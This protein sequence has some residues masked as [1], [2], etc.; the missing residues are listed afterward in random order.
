MKN[1]NGWL[2][3]KP[4]SQS[5]CVLPDGSGMVMVPYATCGGTKSSDGRLGGGGLMRQVKLYAGSFTV[6]RKDIYG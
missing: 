4:S 3:D 2:A 1:I 6:V 5:V